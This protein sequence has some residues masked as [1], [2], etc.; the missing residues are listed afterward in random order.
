MIIPE[1]VVLVKEVIND[2][3][4]L[5]GNAERFTL[6]TVAARLQ[7]PLKSWIRERIIKTS[8]A[9]TDCYE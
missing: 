1:S 6:A 5:I 2:N 3:E 8:Y 7:R 9:F 4:T